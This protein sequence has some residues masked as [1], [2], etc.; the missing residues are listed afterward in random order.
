MKSGETV[1]CVFGLAAGLALAAGASAQTVG[2]DVTYQELTDVTNYGAVGG[3]RGYALGSSTC[4]IG[5]QNLRWIN[6][7]SPVLAMNAYRLHNGRLVQIGQGWSKTACC[8]AAGS[9]CAPTCN[10]QGG[11]VLGAGCRD[12]YGGGFNGI[13]SKLQPRSAVNA[14]TGAMSPATTASGD[15]IFR[16]LQVRQTDMNTTTF[17]NATFFV[18]GAYIAD[19]DAP[20][21][22]GLNNTS[23]K[24]V[25]I[26]QTSFDMTGVGAMQQGIPAIQAWRDHG[27]GAGVADPTVN[28]STFTVPGEGQYWLATKVTPLRD[29]FY[30]YDYAIY[31]LNSDRSGGSLSI[32]L[33][34]GVTVSLPGFNDVNYHSGEPYDNTDWRST[35]TPTSIRWDSPQAFAQNPNSNAL[36]WGTMY[37]FWFTADSAPTRVD[38]T[39][40]LFKPGTPTSISFPVT[41]PAA[42]CTADWNESGIVDSQ[43]FF[44]FLADLFNGNADFNNSGATD[45]QDFFDF[46]NAFFVPCP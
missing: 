42:R 6:A 22:N 11:N 40:G 2:P 17:P 20:A 8:A 38:A 31:N 14:F 23:H 13:Q 43:D 15:A 19:D 34:A 36:R 7:G 27:L 10:N 4:N 33:G 18:E 46:V 9:G 32:P 24:R 12:V 3:V 25:T 39:F 16:R 45:S 44:D 35:I 26:T 30:L 37:N 41:A 21:G 1:R 28:I 29:G 5:N